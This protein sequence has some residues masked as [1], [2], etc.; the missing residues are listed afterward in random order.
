MTLGPADVGQMLELVARTEP[1]PFGPETYRMG[2]YLG[3]RRSGAL[4]AMAGERLR[5][6]G[7]TEISAVCTDPMFRGRG[8]AAA[9]VRTVAAGIDARGETAFLH[10]MQSNGAV[11]LYEALGFEVEAAYPITVVQAP[12]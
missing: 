5:P 10:V 9:L 1:G 3:I 12:G 2:R 4:I 6:P 7:W 11:R 8:L